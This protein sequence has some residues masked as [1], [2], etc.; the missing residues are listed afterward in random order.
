M[1]HSIEL[2]GTV[3]GKELRIL[4]YKTIVAK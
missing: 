3:K 2:M 1:K 4:G